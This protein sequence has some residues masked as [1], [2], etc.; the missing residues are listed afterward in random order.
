MNDSLRPSAY[1]HGEKSMTESSTA[2]S[3]TCEACKFDLATLRREYRIRDEDAKPTL[4]FNCPACGEPIRVDV[5]DFG[6]V[7][8]PRERG[9]GFDFFV[10]QAEGAPNPQVRGR[11]LKTHDQLR[12]E[13][14]ELQPIGLGQALYPA[15]PVFRAAAGHE[16]VFPDLP[17]RPEYFEVLS[18]EAAEA[19]RQ[20]GDSLAFRLHMKG[21]P[22]ASSEV[23]RIFA[24][25]Q[26]SPSETNAFSGLYLSI[27]PNVSLPDWKYYLV[28]FGAWDSEADELFEKNRVR[29]RVY[30]PLRA[31]DGAAAN[32]VYRRWFDVGTQNLTGFDRDASNPNGGL[33]RVRACEHGPPEAVAIEF[34]DEEGEVAAGGIFLVRFEEQSELSHE[35]TSLGLDFGTSNTCAAIQGG[36]AV[37]GKCQPIPL[38]WDT[39]DERRWS[40]ELIPS[41]PARALLQRPDL[42]PPLQGF[43]R[44]HDVF[45]SE[46]TLIASRDELKGRLPVR[47]W[48]FGVHFG[49]PRPGI[50]YARDETFKEES[51]VVR[52]FKWRDML[53]QRSPTL[54]NDAGLLQAHYL[55]GFLMSA[56]L[57][58]ALQQKLRSYAPAV[59]V[60]WSYPLAFD[61]DDRRTL[62]GGIALAASLLSDYTGVKFV[63]G[64]SKDEARAISD[65]NQ[66]AD[67]ANDVLVFV[68]LGGG[69]VDLAVKFKPSPSERQTKYVMSAHFAGADLIRAFAGNDEKQASAQLTSN[70][71]TEELLRRVRETNAAHTL[72]SDSTLFRSK[73]EA[74]RVQR[75]FFGFLTEYVARTLAAG[76]LDQ[77]FVVTTP[78]GLT[79]MPPTFR[80][81]FF[82]VGN[83]WGFWDQ[84]FDLLATDILKR[85]GELL[86]E[87]AERSGPDGYAAKVVDA[88]RRVATRSAQHIQ[89]DVDHRWQ[90]HFK[91]LVPWGLLSS[92]TDHQPSAGNPRQGVMGWD[93]T[94]NV[95]GTRYRLPWFMGYGDAYTQGPTCVWSDRPEQVDIMDLGDPE[96]ISETPWYQQRGLKGHASWE[97]SAPF[98]KGVPPIQ[99]QDPGLK[100]YQKQLVDGCS[101][102][103]GDG[104]FL[105]GPFEVL[106]QTLFKNH[107][108]R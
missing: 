87:E 63:P 41:G 37:D 7:A 1:P 69:S 21:V 53:L 47:D 105:R 62:E 88:F 48:K 72:L 80:V 70:K 60:H 36:M 23:R 73:E 16:L 103:R 25:R 77:R 108:H 13:F 75:R 82:F 27:W 102:H 30:A 12:L 28:H 10:W 34:L 99:Q 97:D 85:A 104:I 90:G 22:G 67:H 3:S 81:A 66:N 18:R 19:P 15:V 44:Y 55:V 5:G 84:S 32:N 24:P 98:L 101:E 89:L 17:I 4:R 92:T 50:S 20:N 74:H 29:V 6:A 14:P 100:N 83:G 65:L 51:Y 8:L 46:L 68:D 107:L 58:A 61:G 38:R 54:A 45:P 31:T 95:D 79:R 76:V 26:G 11:V 35:E 49:I 9:T 2:R 106:L 94:L 39:F 93:T 40:L 86:R 78:A 52:E 57:R 96:A 71:S 33:S 56:Y 42:L 43:G 59:K 91:L 64:P